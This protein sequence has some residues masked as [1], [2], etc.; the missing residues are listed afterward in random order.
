L[1]TVVEE[2]MGSGLDVNISQQ[3]GAAV[4]KNGG[5]VKAACLMLR[6]SVKARGHCGS[7][8]SSEAFSEDDYR[9]VH[10]I[11]DR[12]HEYMEPAASVA[13]GFGRRNQT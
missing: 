1:T 13:D 8:F 10:R 9:A 3:S 12:F 6:R 11:L 5:A 7:P 4:G 2:F